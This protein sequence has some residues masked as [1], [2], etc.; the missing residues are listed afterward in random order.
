MRQRWFRVVALAVFVVGLL[1]LAQTLEAQQK[2][3]LSIATGGTGGVYFPYGGAL[4]SLITKNIPNTEAT[5]EVTAASVANMRLLH[6][7]K[8]D[9]AFTLA[10]TLYDAVNGLGS[11]KTDPGSAIK[12]FALASLYSNFTHLVTVEGR[13]ITK[14]EDVKGKRVSTGAPASGTELIAVRI[15]EAIGLDATKDIKQEKLGVAESVAAMK[16]NKIDAFVWSG[17]LPTAAVQDLANTP[18]LKMVLIDVTPALAKLQEKFGKDLYVRGTI[19]KSAYKTANDVP[20]IVVLNVLVVR[21]GFETDLANAIIKLMF[22][23]RDDLL[24]V[25][26]VVNELTLESA[27]VGSPAPFHPGAIKFYCEKKVWPK[28]D[29][30]K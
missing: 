15:L 16:D 29:D 6:T 4:A 17:G 1:V 12:T 18:N 19:P 23:K 2:R 7:K 26:P 3:F 28:A 5:A 21:D 20:T 11:F 24:K 27:V 13:G 10:D 9:M 14:L 8:S 22:D 30:C 25:H